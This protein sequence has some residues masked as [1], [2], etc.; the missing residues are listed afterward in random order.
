MAEIVKMIA[1]GQPPEP[2]YPDVLDIVGQVPSKPYPLD[3]L[4]E[5][6]RRAVSE[7][8]A[9]VKSPV[10]MLA[11]SAIAAGSIAVQGLVKVRTLKKLV[12]PVG[13]FMLTEAESGERKSS[14]EKSFTPFMDRWTAEQLAKLQDKQA[15][16]EADVA[17]WKAQ[18]KG[19][20]LR[21]QKLVKDTPE[22]TAGL[23]ALKTELN[24]LH[25]NEPTKPPI[26]KIRHTDITVEALVKSLKNFPAV[27][28]LT[29]EGAQFFG[30]VAF[31]SGNASNFMAK[32][33]SAYS[34][35]AIDVSRSG[36]GSAMLNN[37]AMTLHVSVQPE[38]FQEWCKKNG[39]TAWDSGFLPRA[40]MA[41][42]ETTQ[43]TRLL[44]SVEEENNAMLET[45][46]LDEFNQRAYEL[47]ALL[48]EQMTATGAL[49]RRTLDLSEEA[50][51]HWIDFY[52]H[53]EQSL[54]FGGYS[55]FI[56]P[57][58]SRAAENAARLAA[59]FHVF[60]NGPE[61][62][63]SQAHMVSACKIIQWHLSETK[64]FRYRLDLPEHY[65]HAGNISQRIARFARER[66]LAGVKDW[67]VITER[68]IITKLSP[69]VVADRKT[70]RPVINELL[71][72][73]HLLRWDDGAERPYVVVNPRIIERKP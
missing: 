24:R 67:Q 18:I 55:E 25:H 30:S 26:P 9:I 16:Y 50:L 13:L 45:P 3:Q 44:G 28:I 61:G 34:D 4:P 58:A 6:F 46:A 20:E 38:V 43:G 8:Q 1:P 66:K 68:H 37:I 52:N 59:I 29:A 73:G 35:E 62:E 23:E 17:A 12:M 69:K 7:A 2:D 41:A 10:A 32:C 27:A 36:D 51:Q 54:G 53:I 42:P 31:Q 15:D 64:R 56:R 63:V 14:G 49:D 47:L 21:I 40:L 39:S 60:D 19:C 72:S 22:D 5:Q 57:A 65:V 70:V 33:N 71:D 11:C 48:P